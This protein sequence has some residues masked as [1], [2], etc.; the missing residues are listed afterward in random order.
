MLCP[1]P[2]VGETEFGLA[3]GAGEPSGL[4]Q[5]A[6]AKCVWFSA[7]EITRQR[8]GLGVRE[9]VL[10]AEHELHPCLVHLEGAEWQLC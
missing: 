9:E 4:V 6:V 3:A 10:R 8:Q 7:C 1:G 5:E 2:V